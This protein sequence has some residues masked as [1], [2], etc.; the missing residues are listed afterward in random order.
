MAA[1]ERINVNLRLAELRFEIR[2]AFRT[3][4][5]QPFCLKIFSVKHTFT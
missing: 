4:L 5:A 3:N 1:H 2:T